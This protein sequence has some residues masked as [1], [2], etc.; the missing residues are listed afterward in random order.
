MGQSWADSRPGDSSLVKLPCQPGT[1]ACGPT[2]LQGTI[3]GQMSHLETQQGPSKAKEDS[4]RHNRPLHP[5]LESGS[6][7]QALRQTVWARLAARAC[8]GTS[9]PSNLAACYLWS[10]L[11][12][13]TLFFSCP[14]LPS[15]EITELLV[16]DRW[17]VLK[18]TFASPRTVRS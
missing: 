9:L 3:L 15:T 8:L 11:R 17:F 16:C 5:W 12:Y 1:M 6:L 10:R 14:T 4:R 2:H 13:S 18:V 7:P